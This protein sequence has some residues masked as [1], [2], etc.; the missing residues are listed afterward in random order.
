MRKFKVVTI[1]GD[2]KNR[3]KGKSFLIREKSAFETEKWCARA[4]SALS[5][6]GVEI[7]ED[8]LQAGAAGLF[9]TGIEALK[10]LQFEEAEPLMD[11]MLSCITFVPDVNKIGENGRPLSRPLMLGDDED[12]G[13]IEDVGTLTKLRGEVIELHLGFSMAAVLSTMA[14][15]VNLRQQATPTSLEA[16]EP[17]SPQAMPA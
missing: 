7:D 8:M 12:D 11:E 6:S 9:F 2:Q 14:A 1:D 3:D 4:L 10:R 17:S 5:R 13:D 16:S 15:A